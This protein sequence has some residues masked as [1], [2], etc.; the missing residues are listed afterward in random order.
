VP[1]AVFLSF[2]LDLSNAAAGS[3]RP[4]AWGEPEPFVRPDPAACT[5]LASRL[6]LARRP[7]IVAG[8]GAR[9]AT[10]EL[11]ALAKRLSIPVITTPHGKG[12][13]PE[14]DPLHLGLIGLGGH[15]SAVSYLMSRPDVVCIVGSR[16]GD[17]PTDG[18]AIPLTGTDATIQIDRDRFL[19]GRNYPVT[20]GIVSDAAAALRETLDCIPAD[21]S[22]PNR[23]S[24]IQRYRPEDATSDSV[25]LKPARVLS[26][27]QKAFPDAFWFAD[28]GEHCAFALH[29]LAID[30][31][32]RFRSLLGWA[33]MGSGFGSAM[34]FQHARPGERVVCICGD[35]GFMMH[36]GEILTCVENGIDMV[37]VVF[38]DGRFNMVHHGL[39][40]V[41]GRRPGGLPSAIS[42]IAGV[43]RSLGA[44]SL[45]VETPDDL[46]V[47]T[48]RRL[49]EQGGPVVLDVRIDRECALSVGS[50]TASLRHAAFA[51]AL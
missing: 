6:V 11:F 47:D 9:N 15:T 38:N 32:E 45:K 28:Q 46:R 2:P 13:F 29:Y 4:M 7:L 14:S 1:G 39:E 12:V 37:L 22:R 49:A 18:W 25:P 31:P 23:G 40:A 42:D 27:M 30:Q 33:S 3:L 34:G 16:L 24:G 19:I 20:L 50:R 10:P 43:A 41:F 51:G 21:F 26:A 44:Q 5:E 36:A 8:N 35:G 17:L 48:L